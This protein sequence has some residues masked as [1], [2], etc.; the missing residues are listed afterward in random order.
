MEGCPKHLGSKM[1]SKDS[2]SN[3]GNEVGNQS[4]LYLVGNPNSGKS[5]LFNQLTGLKQKTGNF[6]GVTI[7]KKIGS[8][9]FGDKQISLV[10]LPGTLGPGAP[11]LEKK[12]TYETLLNRGKSD[13]AIYVLDATS[14]ERGLQFLF[15]IIDMGIPTLLVLTM[16]DLLV[17]NNVSLD[18]KQMEEILGLQI[19]LINAKSGEGIQELKEKLSQSESFKKSERKWSWEPKRESF[20]L[21]LCNFLGA[22]SL[23]SQYA[24]NES[25]KF[26]SK[27][28]LSKDPRFLDQFSDET[29]A[30]LKNQMEKANL[31][32]DYQSELIQKAISIKKILSKVLTSQEKQTP[33]FENKMDSFFLHPLYGTLFFLSLMGLLFQTLFS[34]AEIPMQAIELGIRFLQDSISSFLP[35]GPFQNLVVDGIVGGVGTVVTFIPQISLLFLFMGLLEESGYMARAS[36]LM[37]KLMGKFGISG[38]SFIPLLSSSACAVPAILGTRTI[39]NKAERFTTILVSPLVMC[40]AR[41]PIYILVVGTVFTS[42]PILGVFNLQGIVLFGMFVLGMLA[43]LFFALL[44]KKTF[45]KSDSSYFIMEL[46]HYNV[47]SFK[48]VFLSVYVKIKGFLASAGQI[49]LYISVLLWFFSRFPGD[50]SLDKW[51]PSPIEQSYVAQMGKTIEPLIEPLGYDWKIGVSL[52]TSF[53]AREVMVSTLAILYQNE[54][55]NPETSNDLRQAMRLDTKKNQIT[56]LWSSLTGLSLLVFFAFASQCMST[57]AVV[58]KE[59]GSAL[60]A[61]FQFS[62]MSILAYMSAFLVYQIGLLLGFS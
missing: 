38:K 42:N 31:L 37:D 10:D 51:K 54:D 34:W 30:V 50:N 5:T 22:N 4:I 35:S 8:I 57:L 32:F 6:H 36:F 46:P 61:F 1:K 18:L 33:N 41:Y 53:A 16:K 56:P 62:Y 21:K 58:K 44:F 39:E 26:L 13:L 11:S 45:F 48:S 3:Q 52:I 29:Q 2:A 24:L 14:L 17:K 12:I 60:W 47:P 43:S 25:L 55:E 27:D 15:Q 23:E 7:E 20:F 9:S 59:T 40:S 19:H 49:I 28:P